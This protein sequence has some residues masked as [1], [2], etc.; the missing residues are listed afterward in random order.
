MSVKGFQIDASVTDLNDV[1]TAGSPAI[2]NGDVLVWNSV[3]GM[4]EHQPHTLPG[5]AALHPDAYF[6]NITTGTGSPI[7]ITE[8]VLPAGWT[9]AYNSVGNF[10]ITHGLGNSQP[11][12][13]LNVMST[14][15][16]LGVRIINPTT[17]TTTA[18]TFQIDDDATTVVEGQVVG[19]LLFV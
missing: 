8:T 15:S 13:A 3:S 10:T 19:M 9:T 4:W 17:I 11:G 7:G 12:F 6:V 14:G 1:S 2:A 5:G 18:V 16:P